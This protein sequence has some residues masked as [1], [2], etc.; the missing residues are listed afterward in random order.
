MKRSKA[1]RFGENAS[2]STR[3]V[4][5]TVV[6]FAGEHKKWCENLREGLV[7]AEQ[8]SR[9]ATNGLS[10]AAVSALEQVRAE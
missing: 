4:S 3:D 2:K 1:E 7:A 9:E 5:G 8:A 6:R 10:S